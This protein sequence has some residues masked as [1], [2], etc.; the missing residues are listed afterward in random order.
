MAL[1]LEEV[2]PQNKGP[3]QLGAAK[4]EK[5]VV[6]SSAIS[7]QQDFPKGLRA[8]VLADFHCTSLIDCLVLSHKQPS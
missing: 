4:K 7:T 6:S 2:E 3:H 5:K 1:R 8:L